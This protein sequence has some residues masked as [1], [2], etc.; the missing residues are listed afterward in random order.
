MGKVDSTWGIF[1]QV[2]AAA[3]GLTVTAVTAFR[4]LF[5]SHQVGRT[6]GSPPVVWRLY[7]KTKEAMRRTFTLRTWL[8]KST[9][10]S[11]TL[12]ASEEGDIELGSIERGTITGLRSFIAGYRKTKPDASQSTAMGEEDDTLPLSEKIMA[13]GSSRANDKILAEPEKVRVPRGD[14]KYV[15]IHDSVDTDRKSGTWPPGRQF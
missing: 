8:S 11:S 9:K 6:Q 13:S 5:V 12:R 14:H 7:K 4:S 10:D 2:M 15:F 3:L 1:W